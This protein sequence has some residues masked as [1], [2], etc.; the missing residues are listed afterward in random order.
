MQS[1]FE[2]IPNTSYDRGGYFVVFPASAGKHWLAV[3][4]MKPSR[5][6]GLGRQPRAIWK[7]GG[8]V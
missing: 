8:V 6:S 2:V 1:K 7:D 3:L 5:C 4:D